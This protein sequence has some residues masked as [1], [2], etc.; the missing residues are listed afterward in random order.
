MY[1]IRSYYALPVLGK[2]VHPL[3]LACNYGIGSRDV[4]EAVDAGINYIFWTR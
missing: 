2:T 1:A 3:G 4:R